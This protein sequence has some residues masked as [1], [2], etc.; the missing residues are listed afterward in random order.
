MSCSFG[1]SALSIESMCMVMR[2]KKNDTHDKK[3]CYMKVLNLV[4]YSFLF[5]L[6]WSQE[7][8]QRWEVSQDRRRTTAWSHR[9]GENDT[10]EAGCR[11]F[12]EVKYSLLLGNNS[13]NINPKNLQKKIRFYYDT[14]LNLVE[15]TPPHCSLNCVGH[16]SRA[17]WYFNVSNVAGNG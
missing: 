8:V 7:G 10:G 11:Y 12:L 13:G 5:I 16:L 2:E 9:G 14:P 6:I 3:E 17:Q 15:R 1:Q 4:F